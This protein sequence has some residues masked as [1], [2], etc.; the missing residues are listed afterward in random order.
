MN[1][2]LYRDVQKTI[3]RLLLICQLVDFD[4]FV[5]INISVGRLVFI[6]LHLWAYETN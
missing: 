3:D 2:K 6:F 1:T 4:Y 5:N